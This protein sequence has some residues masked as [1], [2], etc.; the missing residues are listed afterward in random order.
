MELALEE[1]WNWISHTLETP[2]ESTTV[3]AEENVIRIKG[4][5]KEIVRDADKE[6]TG[7]LSSLSAAESL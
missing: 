6:L 4:K 2:V 5:D 3:A 7:N 1:G